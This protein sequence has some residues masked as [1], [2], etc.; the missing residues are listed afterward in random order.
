MPREFSML[1][2]AQQPLLPCRGVTRQQH[3]MV[4]VSRQNLHELDNSILQK[5]LRKVDAPTRGYSKRPK[6]IQYLDNYFKRTRDPKHVI[7]VHLQND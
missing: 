6:A 7:A 4:E 5:A 2:S 3:G 1:P